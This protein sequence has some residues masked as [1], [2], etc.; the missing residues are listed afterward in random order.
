VWLAKTDH[1]AHSYS[2]ETLAGIIIRSGRFKTPFWTRLHLPWRTQQDLLTRRSLGLDI[3]THWSSRWRRSV[4]DQFEESWC[5]LCARPSSGPHQEERESFAHILFECPSL[6]LHAAEVAAVASQLT[7]QLGGLTLYKN[8]HSV[9]WPDLPL[10]VRLGLLMGNRLACFTYTFADPALASD[11]LGRFLTATQRPISTL[12]KER[13]ALV[14][15]RFP[16]S[17]MFPSSQTSACS[18]QSPSH[19]DTPS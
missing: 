12:L 19:L 17:P 11:W 5:P 4:H 6:A 10:E 8:T 15:V 9:Q 3:A 13:K 2:S 18:I 1:R 16:D 14:Q 7:A